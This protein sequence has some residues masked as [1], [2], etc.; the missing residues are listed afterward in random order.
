MISPRNEADMT[1]VHC[2]NHYKGETYCCEI[3]LAFVSPSPF[4]SPLPRSPSLVLVERSVGIEKWAKDGKKKSTKKKTTDRLTKRWLE[5]F[6]VRWPPR[7]VRAK[8]MQ[9]LDG[10]TAFNCHRVTFVSVPTFHASSSSPNFPLENP[11]ADTISSPE[12]PSDTSSDQELINSAAADW[13]ADF[14]GNNY[15]NIADAS[16]A[17]LG[18]SEVVSNQFW[19]D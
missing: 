11:F 12:I 4:L 1:A 7:P 15:I 17:D 16:N 13:T 2:K 5:I 8:N 6:P 14:G 19:V 10:S 18:D 3:F 9:P